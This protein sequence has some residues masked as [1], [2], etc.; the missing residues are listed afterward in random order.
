MAP[1]KK[2]FGFGG[3]S[4]KFG[5]EK[6]RRRLTRALVGARHQRLD[7]LD[8]VDDEGELGVAGEA[9]FGGGAAADGDEVVGER[10]HEGVDVGR[11]DAPVRLLDDRRER[12]QALQP[13]L[14]HAHARTSQSG[15]PGR[16]TDN[17]AEENHIE[18]IARHWL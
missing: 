11:G 8:P 1:F 5:N 10:R 4:V 2:Q 9:A 3:D 13:R 14:Q 6:R 12:L 7:D 15:S 16:N 17:R 18:N